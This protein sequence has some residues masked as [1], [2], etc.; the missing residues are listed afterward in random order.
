[1]ADIGDAYW[2]GG[3]GWE[4]IGTYAATFEGNGH[5]LANLFIARSE[6]DEVGF[7]GRLGSGSVVRN[8]GLRGGGHH[9][10]E[11]GRWARRGQ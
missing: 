4:P 9:G 8:V 6:T 2:N 5:R 10:A 11:R 3:M 7:F 1:M